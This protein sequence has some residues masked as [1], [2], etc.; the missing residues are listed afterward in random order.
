MA[1]TLHLG[2]A[3]VF[4]D[5]AGDNVQ[6]TTEGGV[7]IE[8]GGEKANIATDEGG[9]SPEDIVM[10][11][12]TVKATVQLADHDKDLLP[13]ISPNFVEVDDGETP[14]AWARTEFRARVGLKLSTV[15]KVLKIVKVIDGVESTDPE[16]MFYIFKAVATGTPRWEFTKDKQ[17]VIAVD[18]EGLVDRA[19]NNRMAMIGTFPGD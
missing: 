18:F 19:N 16:D 4:W 14:P 10:T 3:N 9:T 7:T 8:F 13:V 17:S 15:A 5:P 1:E 2:P 11:G 12:A 6:L